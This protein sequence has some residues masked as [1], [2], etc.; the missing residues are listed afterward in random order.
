MQLLKE[1]EKLRHEISIL[2][3]QLKI[4]TNQ[5]RMQS[6]RVKERQTPSPLFYTNKSLSP[7][8][9]QNDRPVKPFGVNLKST[10][11]FKIG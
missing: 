4:Y 3:E 5:D 8:V 6:S 1:N 11:L 2:K 10:S 7:K 9:S